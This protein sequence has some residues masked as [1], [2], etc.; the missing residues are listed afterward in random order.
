MKFKKNKSEK[1]VTSNVVNKSEEAVKLWD[2]INEKFGNIN[3]TCK[4]LEKSIQNLSA[5]SNLMKKWLKAQTITSKRII[6]DT[7][8]KLNIT[9]NHLRMAK[10]NTASLKRTRHVVNDNSKKIPGFP[11]EL[12]N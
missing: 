7:V 6:N 12:P 10:L 1:K 9:K 5:N 2:V 11:L 4:T 8:A 3:S